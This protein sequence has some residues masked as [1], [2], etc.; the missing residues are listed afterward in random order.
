M[1]NE[2][3]P[4]QRRADDGKYAKSIACDGCGKP[5]KDDHMTD[6]EACGGSDGPG[7]FLCHRKRCVAKLELMTPACRKA[8]YTL[9]RAK[10][11]IR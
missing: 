4:M 3:N 1:L 11:N 10:N 7:F 8:H 6:E 2:R 5:C 9:Q